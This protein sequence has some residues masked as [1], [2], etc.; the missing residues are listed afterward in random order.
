[1]KILSVS[2]INDFTKKYLPEWL[3][4]IIKV[5]LLEYNGVEEYFINSHYF[6]IVKDNEVIQ[7][8]IQ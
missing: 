1:M 4:D 3:G 7:N 8:D 5:S 6:V 2:E